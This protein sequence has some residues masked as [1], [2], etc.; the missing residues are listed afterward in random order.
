MNILHVIRGLTNSSG[1][2]H[3]VG[4]IAEAQAR[5][6]HDVQVAYLEKPPFD[7]VL[8][9]PSC[10]RSSSLGRR[11]GHFGFIPGLPARLRPFVNWASVVHVHAIW[12][13]MSLCAMRVALEVGK[14]CL[15]APQGSLDPVAWRLGSLPRKV[16]ARCVEF[17]F[18]RRAQ[19]LQA[20]T[21]AEQGQ[22]FEMGLDNPSY[23]L[24]NGVDVASFA[25]VDQRCSDG[26][27]RLLFLGRLHPKK[28]LD[29]LVQSLAHM[30]ENYLLSIA[31]SDAGSG[32]RSQIEA[33]VRKLG[34][35]GRVSWLGEVAGSTK[36]RALQDS[37]VF[38]LP[39]RSEGQPI[40]V[41]EAL[42]SGRPVVLSPACNVSE[43][44]G[45]GAGIEVELRP[46]AIAQGVVG[47]FGELCAR[48]RAGKAARELAQTRFAW[49]RV[50]ERSIDI[51]ARLAEASAGARAC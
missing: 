17:R 7:T 48:Q 35:Q 36:I 23:V 28:G 10:V 2:T 29:L 30:P 31:G 51:Y 50:A 39:S 13:Y 22:F 24:P 27:V 42:A 43:V 20:L 16:Y 38:V 4:P 15:V 47:A 40:A 33:Q 26:A 49:D 3:I 41:L 18:L 14:P 32:Y 44:V 9:N 21:A 45:A 34:V 46:S 11:A 6:G 37:D 12:N 25:G 19:A 1:T 5:A 8:P